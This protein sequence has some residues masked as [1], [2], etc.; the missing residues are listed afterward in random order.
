MGFRF[1]RSVKICKGV[2][3]NVSKSG[4]S[5]SFGGK[6]F[7]LNASG[8]GLRGTASIPGT[9][10]SYSSNLTSS[11]SYRTPRAAKGTVAIPNFNEV[12]VGIDE[13]GQLQIFDS[14]GQLLEAK[15]LRKFKREYK[16]EIENLYRQFEKKANLE[17][18]LILDLQQRFKD[19]P[20]QEDWIARRIRRTFSGYNFSV[21]KPHPE[22][23]ESRSLEKAKAELKQQEGQGCLA[24]CFVSTIPFFFLM[25][26]IETLVELG[27][28]SMFLLPVLVPLVY[29][30]VNTGYQTKLKRLQSKYLD[31]SLK[32]SLL[33]WEQSKL[34][35]EKDLRSQRERF[36]TEES[37]RLETL[38]E[39]ESGN[40][41]EIQK[42]LERTFSDLN[43][44]FDFF[45]NF[46][47]P[48]SSTAYL[49]IDLPEIEDVP[50]QK[51]NLRKDGKV[52][53]KNKSNKE[54]SEHYARLCHSMLFWFA[55]IVFDSIP[56]T[57]ELFLS[58]YT[59]RINPKTGAVQDD[60][61]LAIRFDKASMEEL[62]LTKIDP[63]EAI[64]NFEYRRKMTKNYKLSAISPFEP[65]NTGLAEA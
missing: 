49:D 39:L 58:G 27:G 28:V 13:G 64:E 55:I 45:V 54:L 25:T 61:V 53:L 43:F 40:I 2:R 48:N 16:V 51:A 36:E 23:F 24:G 47:I 4:L 9:G 22:D 32:S 21:P 35:Y 46:E 63:I 1:R 62:F 56:T 10:L 52:S 60:Y 8:R 12:Q 34:N 14:S 65:P 41:D 33:N 17:T 42:E 30:A 3:L 7:T 11:H 18:N 6:G 5:T 59:Q 44:H 19:I 38:K 26:G 29:Y 31:E 15:V 37:R 50:E 20:D 57:S